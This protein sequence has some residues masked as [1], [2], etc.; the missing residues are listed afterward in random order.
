MGFLVALFPGNSEPQVVE[1][2]PP[3]SYARDAWVLDGCSTSCG[4]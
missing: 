2:T 1:Q 4:V 3:P